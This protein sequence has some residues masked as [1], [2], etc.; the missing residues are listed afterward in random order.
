MPGVIPRERSG[1]P[2][3]DSRRKRRFVARIV[4]SSLHSGRRIEAKEGTEAVRESRK[5][6][7]GANRKEGLFAVKR[8]MEPLA[9]GTELP[10]G[11]AVDGG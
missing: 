11:K 9:S 10:L 5:Q 1:K 7:G 8:A 2:N 6:K 4:R 3:I